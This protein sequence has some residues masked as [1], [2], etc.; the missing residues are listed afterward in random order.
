M[1]QYIQGAGRLLLTMTLTS[2]LLGGCSSGQSG[3]GQAPAAPDTGMGLQ[4]PAAATG[5]SEGKES[6]P[7]TKQTK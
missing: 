3:G 4:K 1:N 6:L 2:A 5:S 7:V